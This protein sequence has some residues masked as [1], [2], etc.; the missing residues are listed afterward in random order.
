MANKYI[1]LQNGREK[2]IEASTVSAGSA[3]AGKIFAVGS[4]G[5][6]DPSLIPG[7]DVTA[8]EASENLSAGNYVNL[9]NDAGDIK[10]RKADASNDRPAHGYVND[11]VT[12]GN[13]VS[14]YFEGANTGQSGLTP[15]AR[16]YLGAAGVGTNTVPATPGS[17][18]HQFLGIAISATEVNTDIDDEIVL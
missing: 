18:I 7:I 3:D 6:Y 12:S 9:W 5:K 8:I 15:G 1:T 14:V 2:M 16:V 10:V 17:V 13:P 11:T 4:N